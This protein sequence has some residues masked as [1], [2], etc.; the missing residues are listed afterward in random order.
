MAKLTKNRFFNYETSPQG[1][2]GKQAENNLNYRYLFVLITKMLTN[3]KT[4]KILEIGCG[5]GRNLL[6]IKKEFKDQ[7]ELYGTDISQTSI[8]YARKLKIGR[9]KKAEAQEV[10]FYE[11]FDLILI[12]D[13]LEHLPNERVVVKTLAKA[14]QYIKDSPGWLYLSVPIEQNPLS[15]TWFYHWLPYARNWTRQFYGHTLQFNLDKIR[16]MVNQANFRAKDAF[17]SVHTI[18]QFQTLFFYFIPK[19]LLWVFL[20]RKVSEG[21]RDAN[22]TVWGS[23]HRWLGKFKHLFVNLGRSLSFLADK[24]SSLRQNHALAAGNIHLLLE[25]RKES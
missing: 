24:E 14:R 7:V 9:F 20:G 6:A 18:S 23:K 16:K 5:G 1:M 12:I 15:L 17:Y 4:I 8:N 13:L 22:E 3:K 19:T 2:A 25:P 21:L 10:P 11:K